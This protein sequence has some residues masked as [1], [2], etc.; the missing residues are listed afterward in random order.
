MFNEPE[1]ALPARLSL[2]T[3]AACQWCGQA[4]RALRNTR[5]QNE[6]GLTKVGPCTFV[7]PD[8]DMMGCSAN[9]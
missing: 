1:F 6:D 3:D 2:L 9:E 4:L 7:C 5:G 8:C